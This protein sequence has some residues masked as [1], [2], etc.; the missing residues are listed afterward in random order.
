MFTVKAV[1]YDGSEN[2]WQTRNVAT[3]ARER[4]TST[5][6]LVTESIWFQADND[7]EIEMSG[8]G[9][10]VYV[11]NDNGKTVSVYVLDGQNEVTGTP[12]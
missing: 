1:Y 2:I 8:N 7:A 3:R 4:D 10:T 9:A 5:A 11:M 6:P 12:V